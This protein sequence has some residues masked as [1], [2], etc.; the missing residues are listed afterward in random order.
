MVDRATAALVLLLGNV[1]KR[2]I[3][4]RELLTWV[5]RIVMG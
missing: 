2:V 1:V 5:L 3:I 4:I